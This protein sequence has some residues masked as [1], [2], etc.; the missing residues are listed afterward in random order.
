MKP[1][2]GGIMKNGNWKWALSFIVGTIIGM[3]FTAGVW[4]ATIRADVKANTEA[5]KKQD[6]TIAENK[7]CI[8]N[9]EKAIIGIDE[10]LA[11]LVVG[12]KK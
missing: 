8:T 12:Y 1:K 9:V 7:T 4:T 5:N 3:V 2:I 6:T 10:K 11:L